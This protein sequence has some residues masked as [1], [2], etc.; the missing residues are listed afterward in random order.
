MSRIE[1]LERDKEFIEKDYKALTQSILVKELEIEK[2]KKEKIIIQENYLKIEESN[3]N[4][5]K[6]IEELNKGNDLDQL[7]ELMKESQKVSEL[8]NL[9]YQKEN[10]IVF[11]NED[12]ALIEESYLQ[13]IKRAAA[14]I[15]CSDSLATK[16]LFKYKST[17]FT[18]K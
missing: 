13:E 1:T 7:E 14:P 11:L 12:R 3:K 6:E 9:L 16:T 2:L 4:N 18:A 5:L 15:S 17:I 10:E 8:K